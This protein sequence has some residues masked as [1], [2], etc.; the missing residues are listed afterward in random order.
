M[1]QSNSSLSQF[2]EHQHQ[3]IDELLLSHQEALVEK[4]ID[5]AKSLFACFHRALRVHAQAEDRVL[6]ELH[7]QQCLDP[8]W[9]T[10]I[11]MHEHRKIY[12]LLDKMGV[13]I[14]E[15]ETL[16]TRDVIEILDEQKTL[17]GVIEHHGEREEKG[18]MAELENVLSA[19]DKVGLMGRLESVWRDTNQQIQQTLAGLKLGLI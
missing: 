18:M 1:T 2:I 15:L 6:L 7:R 4:R 12:D 3:W 13:R 16:T 19:E 10:S 17:K 5:A 8:K 14:H 11:Y 9:N